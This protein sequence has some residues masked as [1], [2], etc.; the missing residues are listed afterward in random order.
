MILFK[1]FRSARQTTETGRRVHERLLRASLKIWI[2]LER[3]QFLSE[4][5]VGKGTAAFG[6]HMPE[7]LEVFH[8]ALSE[9][10]SDHEGR[11]A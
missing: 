1:Q 5:G 2:L 7:R 11:A 8:L 6:P 3:N 10:E 4:A 9:Q